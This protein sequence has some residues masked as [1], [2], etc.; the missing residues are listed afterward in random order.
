VIDENVGV[1]MHKRLREKPD[2]EGTTTRFDI[3]TTK[4]VEMKWDVP[5]VILSV[6]MCQLRVPPQAGQ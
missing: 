3:A 2:L 6:G 4:H 1:D 5:R